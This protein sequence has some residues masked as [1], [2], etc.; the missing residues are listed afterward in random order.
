MRRLSCTFVVRICHKTRVRMIWSIYRKIL[1]IR[2]PKNCCNHPKIGTVILLYRVIWSKGCRHNTQCKPWSDWSASTLF[3]QTT[4]TSD[5]KVHVRL[6]STWK[7]SRHAAI[8]MSRDMIKRTK[9]LCAKRRLS[10]GIRAVWSESSLS[11][12]RKLGS[13]ATHW[14]QR[15][16]WSD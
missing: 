5:H 11:A 14:A 9:W 2:T 16:L 8:Q 1:N 10:L 15:R 12:W 4:K 6:A 13:L 3:A 7:L